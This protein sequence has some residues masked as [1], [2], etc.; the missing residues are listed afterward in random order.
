MGGKT[1]TISLIRLKNILVKKG[2]STADIDDA[3]AEASK[4]GK[5][6][7]GI[8]RDVSKRVCAILCRP[9]DSAVIVRGRKALRVFTTKGYA[10]LVD[11][12]RKNAKARANGEHKVVK[13]N[14]NR[15]LGSIGRFA[16]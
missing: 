11:S 5:P 1:G 2:V 13:L 12:N 15:D 3:M 16:A 7:D 10:R 8:P 9:G 6:L 14:T 4:I